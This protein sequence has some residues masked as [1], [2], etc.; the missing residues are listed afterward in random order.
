MIGPNSTKDKL[1]KLMAEK[2]DLE[3]QIDAYGS[4]LSENDNVGMRGPLVDSEGFPRNDIDIYKVRQA[5]QQI[6]C[7]QNN[8]KALMKTIETLM[9][10]LHAEARQQQL[11]QQTSDMHLNDRSNGSSENMEVCVNGLTPVKAIVKI[12]HVDAGSPAEKAGLRSQDEIAEFGSINCN[13]FNKEL[14]SIGSVVNHMRNQ[15]IPLKV[16]RSN[17]VLDIILI[18][19]RWPG[20]GL[21][22][23]NIVLCE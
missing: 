17:E 15:R 3:I 11:T 7:L 20:N 1:L 12:T 22:G 16:L 2:R 14:S 19:Q 9:H 6:I 13:N 18:P 21:L 10:Q 23:C 4:I 5:R 8:H